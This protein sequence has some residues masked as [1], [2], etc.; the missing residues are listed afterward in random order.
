MVFVEK[1]IIFKFYIDTKMQTYKH[2]V[3]LL[4][5]SNYFKFYRDNDFE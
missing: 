3:L 2:R 5:Q 1:T 4:K